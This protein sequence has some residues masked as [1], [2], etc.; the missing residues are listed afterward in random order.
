MYCV[1]ARRAGACEGGLGAFVDCILS[2]GIPMRR[3]FRI[4]SPELFSRLQSEAR[5]F[6][7]GAEACE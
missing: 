3:G 4:G 2:L 5:L 1:T 6:Q 7:A